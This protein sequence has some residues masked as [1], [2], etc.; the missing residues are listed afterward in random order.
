MGPWD[1]LGHIASVFTWVAFVLVVTLGVVGYFV[2]RAAITGVKKSVALVKTATAKSKEAAERVLK[3]SKGVFQTVQHTAEDLVLVA[4]NGFESGVY[5]LN[6]EFDLL[7]ENT[8]KAIHFVQA[9]H[10]AST[11]ILTDFQKQVNSLISAGTFH[12]PAL[13]TVLP[14]AVSGMDLPT[15]VTSSLN[16]QI[17]SLTEAV[18]QWHYRGPSGAWAST[19]GA[20]ELDNPVVLPLPTFKLGNETLSLVA[21]AAFTQVNDHAIHWTVPNVTFAILDVY[22][23]RAGQIYKQT[24]SWL[25]V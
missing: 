11:H 6:K 25:P 9:G 21:N 17:H 24:F 16:F 10:F 22:D 4:R 14:T 18:A 1:L 15:G 20:N 8:D 5:R 19:L 2:T 12:F 13:P 23:N 7:K 3:E